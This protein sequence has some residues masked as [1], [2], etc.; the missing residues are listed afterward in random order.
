[1]DSVAFNRLPTEGSNKNIPRPPSVTA[2]AP[3]VP[4]QKEAHLFQ[5]YYR[6]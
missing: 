5:S 2:H 1:M 6:T 4:A 3:K